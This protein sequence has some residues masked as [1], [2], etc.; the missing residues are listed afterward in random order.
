MANVA[1][2]G[3]VYGPYIHRNRWRVVAIDVDGQRSAHICATLSEA[4]E[5][6]RRLDAGGSEGAPVRLAT[7]LERYER[8]LMHKGN[9]AMSVATTI[10]RLR[11]FFGDQLLY[12]VR[13]LDRET[14]Q[15]LYDDQIVRTAVDTHRNALSEAKTFLS[16]CV[17]HR[18]L[19]LNPAERVLPLGK[20]RH[21]KA[22]LHIN[23][24][25]AWM[26]VATRL[27]AR[28]QPGAVAAMM[29]LLMG[30]RASEIVQCAARDIDRCGQ[31]LWIP[32]S[33]T[34]AGKRVLEVPPA[35]QPHLLRLARDRAPFERL[36]EHDRP[37]VRN[38]VKR[39]CR[40]AHV[41]IVCA[42]AMRGLHSTL[43][44]TAGV[45]P[46]VVAFA[47]GHGS[48]RATLL[49]Y[50]DPGAVA[51]VT[52]QRVLRALRASRRRGKVRGKKRA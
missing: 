11:S 38:W 15:W 43:A 34:E 26:S 40:A 45:T 14:C 44:I 18:Y 7:A 21:G 29:T 46:S 36:F 33:K 25:R 48:T 27:A 10:Y 50:A 13:R 52:Q 39:I 20:R 22:Q 19:A 35:L 16:W 47:L 4:N 12:P 28:R 17:R 1:K 42:H 51:R 8:Y 30:M 31:L 3:R 32:I 2:G 5:L 6:I 49:S 23:E 9:R 24:A 37:W 41:P